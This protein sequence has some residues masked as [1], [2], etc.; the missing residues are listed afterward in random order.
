[1]HLL[2]NVGGDYCAR[3]N[4]PSFMRSSPIEPPLSSKQHKSILQA[5]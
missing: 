5:P 3:G 4:H 2:G 1:M